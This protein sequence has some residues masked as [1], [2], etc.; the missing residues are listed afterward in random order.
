MSYL[1]H[2]WKQLVLLLCFLSFLLS[3]KKSHIKDSSESAQPTELTSSYESVTDFHEQFFC[4]SVFTTEL[5]LEDGT[6]I[7][8]VD[9][10]NDSRFLILVYHL[11]DSWYLTDAQCFA[12]TKNEIPLTGRGNPNQNQFPGKREIPPC[13]LVQNLEFKVPLEALQSETG[14]CPSNARY[15]VAMRAGVKKMANSSDCAI[16]APVEAWAAPVL[17]NPGDASEWASAF[18]YCRQQCDPAP[19]PPAQPSWCAFGQGYWFA[20][21]GVDW[22]QDHV[23]FGNLTVAKDAARALW[24]AQNNVAKKAFFQASALQLSRICNNNNNPL[25]ADIAGD[26]TTLFNFLSQLSYADVESGTVPQGTDLQAIQTAA[27]NIG[28]WI[29]RNNCNPLVDPT[30]CQ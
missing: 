21:P 19:A 26:Y 7:G 2:P 3:C 10:G 23:Q 6:G 29:C 12:G 14:D 5:K 27:G 28:S 15:F 1:I 11:D 18:Y 25:P 22:C 24:P 20:K 9:V 30:V 8:T 4:G 16:G 13:D 17:I